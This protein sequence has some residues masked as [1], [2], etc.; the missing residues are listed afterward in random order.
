MAG[1]TKI[2][3][4]SNNSALQTEQIENQVN[5]LDVIGQKNSIIEEKQFYNLLG[6][7]GVCETEIDLFGFCV[8]HYYADVN[9][10][11]IAIADTFGNYHADIA[12]DIDNDG[13]SE[14]IANI[15]YGGDGHKEVYVFDNIDGQIMVGRLKRDEDTHPGIYWWGVNAVQTEYDA[16]NQVFVIHYAVKQ[17][18]KTVVEHAEYKYYK[19]AFEWVEYIKDSYEN[20]FEYYMY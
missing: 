4:E 18:E 17:G 16:I 5:E 14:L 13:K 20:R 7:D 8:N 1:C 11:E 19:D 9:G 12:L 15:M 10:K 6:Y 3:Q 2:E